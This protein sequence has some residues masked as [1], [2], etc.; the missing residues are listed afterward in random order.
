MDPRFN[1]VFNNAMVNCT[2]IVMKRVL[3]F[4]KGFEHINKLVDVGGGLGI[5]L[6]LITSKYPHLRGINFDLP[7]IIEHAPT[8]AGVEHVGGDMFES[9]PH[10]DVIFMKVGFSFCRQEL[11]FYNFSILNSHY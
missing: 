2:T 11:F 7:H 1:D 10:G 8:Y 4:Y 3:E 9:V 6:N 5:N